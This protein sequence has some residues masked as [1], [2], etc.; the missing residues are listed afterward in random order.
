MRGPESQLWGVDSTV[1]ALAGPFVW[2]GTGRS[3][4]FIVINSAVCVGFGV[5]HLMGRVQMWE[6]FA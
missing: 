2:G 3:N 6:R 5:V 1:Y 4:R